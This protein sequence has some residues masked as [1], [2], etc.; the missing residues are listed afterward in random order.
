VSAAGVGLIR[1]RGRLREVEDEWRSCAE[2][3]GSA[4]LTPDWAL[5]WLRH[6]GVGLELAVLQVR[7][8]HR[9]TIGWMPMALHGSGQRRT[10]RFIGANLADHLH[11]LAEHLGSEAE[12]AAALGAE[13]GGEIDGWSK[14]TLDNVD[15][16]ARWVDALLEAAPTKLATAVT[17]RNEL[18]YVVLPSSWDE[19]LAARSRNFRNEV[20]RKL[21]RLERDHEVRFR[22]TEDPRRL[23]EDLDTFFR[24]HGARWEQR[25]GSSSVTPRARAFH[26]DFSAMA[27]ERGW[28]RLWIMDVDG[29]PAAAWYGWKLGKRYAYYLAGFSQRWADWSVGF[30]LMAHT[31]RAAIEEG[32]SEYDMLL[33]I[34]RAHV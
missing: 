33:E 19:Y 20:G 26:R 16:D 8:K 9:E 6:Y 22:L 32:A 27:L 31:V 12:V 30:L 23:P 4:F 14:V 11:P 24:L 34:G 1:D 21:R 17:R 5:A 7:G 15:V 10:L 2:R 28:L 18:P 3:S 29:E 13:L 25:G